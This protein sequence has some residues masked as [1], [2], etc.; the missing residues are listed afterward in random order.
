MVHVVTEV[1]KLRMEKQEQP[2]N[3]LYILIQFHITYV[4][5]V[6]KASIILKMG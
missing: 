5:S 6:I 1:W 3:P 2:Q 4:T